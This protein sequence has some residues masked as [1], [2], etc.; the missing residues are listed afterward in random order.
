MGRYKTPFESYISSSNYFMPMNTVQQEYSL[1][2]KCLKNWFSVF[3]TI[4]KKLIN[5]ISAVS[6]RDK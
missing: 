1:V 3:L 4:Q 5:E 6:L 2:K